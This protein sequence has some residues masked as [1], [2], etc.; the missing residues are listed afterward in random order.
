MNYDQVIGIVLNF[1]IVGTF[2]SILMQWIRSRWPLSESASKMLLVGIS[3]LIGT[4]VVL[5]AKTSA[6]PT[7][8][9]ILGGASTAYGLFVKDTIPVSSP[10]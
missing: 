3:V 2:V 5:G 6:W 9:A 10:Q 4:V 7:I 1:A 8:L